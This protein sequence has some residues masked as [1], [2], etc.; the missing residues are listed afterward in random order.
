MH[1]QSII[2]LQT[3]A[4]A[5]KETHNL[6]QDLNLNGH[7]ILHANLVGCS[8]G[9]NEA[10]IKKIAESLGVDTSG[11][12]VVEIEK[13]VT[14]LPQ[15]GTLSDADL[16]KLSSDNCLLVFNGSIF[17][18]TYESQNGLDYK[19]IGARTYMN[20]VSRTYFT[21]SKTDGGYTIARS[22]LVEANVQVPADQTLSS[23]KNLK[24]GNTTFA[25][26]E[27]IVVDGT[28]D[29]GAF[30]PAAGSIS[31]ADAVEA[32][33]RGASITLRVSSTNI[34]TY[35]RVTSYV[36]TEILTNHDY[37]VA[38]ISSN[39]D[40]LWVNPDYTGPGL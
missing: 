1:G 17:R 7:S 2:W 19:E 23:M 10:E 38:H 32:F 4:N 40:A 28:F 24:V 20:G 18:K 14:N 27:I 30:V 16:E 22:E 26:P 37:L 3:K 25:V 8:F 29:N 31:Y 21:A 39:G 11:V 12:Q 34:V 5:M 35:H 6:K 36:V 33:K 15:T 13:T 9:G